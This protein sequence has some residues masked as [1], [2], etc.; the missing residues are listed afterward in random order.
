M[1]LEIIF[2]KLESLIKSVERETFAHLLQRDFAPFTRAI[3]FVNMLAEM[4]G[5]KSG[6]IHR[7]IKTLHVLRKVQN[8]SIIKWNESRGR[9]TT[10]INYAV[11]ETKDEVIDSPLCAVISLITATISK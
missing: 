9:G 8:L 11:N 1:A 7:Y 5:R 2:W 6:T 10:Y 3:H 4:K